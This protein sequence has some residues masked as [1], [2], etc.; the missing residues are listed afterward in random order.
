VTIS[1]INFEITIKNLHK[2]GYTTK[3]LEN[4]QKNLKIK[5][6]LMTNFPDFHKIALLESKKNCNLEIVQYDET[7]MVDHT[8]LQPKIINSSISDSEFLHFIENDIQEKTFFDTSK[9][10]EFLNLKVFT[11]DINKSMIFWKKFGFSPISETKNKFNIKFDSLTSEKKYKLELIKK[12]TNAP[13]LNN[14]G[15]SCLAL[16]TNSIVSEKKSLDDDGYFTTDIE[17]LNVGGNKVAIFFCKNTC[18]EIVE[19]ISLNHK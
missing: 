13:F 3:F 11:Q 6:N 18:G 19:L 8:F 17:F 4:K 14:H 16:I 12:P 10:F 1:T 2:L 7:N 5:K 9:D 15:V